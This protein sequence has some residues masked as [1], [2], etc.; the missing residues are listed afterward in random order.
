M[1]Q[2]GTL[3]VPSATLGYGLTSIRSRN[4]VRRRRALARPTTPN[5][6][7]EGSTPTG[8]T[9]TSVYSVVLRCRV[10]RRPTDRVTLCGISWARRTI[11]K[12]AS[13]IVRRGELKRT[14]ILGDLIS[15]EDGVYGTSKSVFAG[16]A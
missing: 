16:G 7:V 13:W 10:P 5:L 15:W 3:A 8:L 2:C 4:H 9:T 1:A 12:V 11:R 14:G 6:L